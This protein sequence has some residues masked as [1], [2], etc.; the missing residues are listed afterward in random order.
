VLLCFGDFSVDRV[1]VFW[2]PGKIY[3]AKNFQ[4]WTVADWVS[5][6]QVWCWTRL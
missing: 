3:L 6:Q 2:S 5:L 4:L 1:L